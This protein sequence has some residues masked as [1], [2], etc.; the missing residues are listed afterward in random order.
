MLIGGLFFR[1][2]LRPAGLL[3]WLSPSSACYLRPV[4]SLCLSKTLLAATTISKRQNRNNLLSLLLE[5]MLD[6][7]LLLLLVHVRKTE[8]GIAL[9]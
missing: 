7:S 6:Y 3:I 8:G 9:N 1:S 2:F 5:F 4:P